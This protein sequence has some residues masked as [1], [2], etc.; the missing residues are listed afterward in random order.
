LK[1]LY[2]EDDLMQQVTVASIAEGLGHEL[3]CESTMANFKTRLREQ[4]FDLILMDNLLE[5]NEDSFREIE[6]VREIVGHS[7]GIVG[8]T[9][10]DSFKK[11]AEKYKDISLLNHLI[12]KPISADNIE[13]ALY[14]VGGPA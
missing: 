2:L 11:L 10:A 12:C 9:G 3:I 5:N 4:S 1:I 8:L 7:V 14:F 13:S 6:L